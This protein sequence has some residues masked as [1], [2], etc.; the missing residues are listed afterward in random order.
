MKFNYQMG[1]K[2]VSNMCQSSPFFTKMIHSQLDEHSLQNEAKRMPHKDEQNNKLSAPNVYKPKIPLLY[3]EQHMDEQGGVIVLSAANISLHIP[4]GALLERTL[5]SIEVKS[6]GTGPSSGLDQS[7]CLTPVVSCKPD[8]QQFHKSVELILP[9]CAEFNDIGLHKA[10]VRFD[11]GNVSVATE[12]DCVTEYAQCVLKERFCHIYTTHFSEVEVGISK[13]VKKRMRFVPF[14]GG[15]HILTVKV[16]LIN[17]LPSEYIILLHEH[18][19]I[20][21]APLNRYGT[22]T[23]D[24]QD[25][26]SL[27]VTTSYNSSLVP[28]KEVL[29]SFDN[30]SLFNN[31]RTSSEF[32]IGR[33]SDVLPANAIT[34]SFFKVPV[35]VFRKLINDGDMAAGRS[36]E[37]GTLQKMGL[38]FP[39]SELLEEMNRTDAELLKEIDELHKELKKERHRYKEFLYEKDKRYQE[40]LKE[41]RT[42]SEELKE[43]RHRFKELKEKLRFHKGV[44]QTKDIGYDELLK[45]VDKQYQ[46]LKEERHR[47]EEL[48]EK[49]RFYEGARRD[50]NEGTCQIQ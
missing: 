10:T 33:K 34:L 5:I 9:H 43:E 14:I 36:D 7:T 19:E 1:T 28:S 44:F 41:N 16:W 18:E 38:D 42:Q 13:C 40:L 35:L 48:K 29:K 11:R 17:D 23:L 49:L 21:F 25:Q 15:N 3:R 45:K 50:R 46:E 39:S 8:G 27:K 32:E 37:T 26:C 20:K 24:V 12:P 22:F 47:C 31:I 30:H 2:E 4:P 6:A